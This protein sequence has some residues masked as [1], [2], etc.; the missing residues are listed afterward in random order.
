MKSK[1][2]QKESKIYITSMKDKR[3]M[4]GFKQKLTEWLWSQKDQEKHNNGPLQ[5]KEVLY[6]KYIFKPFVQVHYRCKQLVILLLKISPKII[7]LNA[8]DI[9]I[10]NLNRVEEETMKS[11][12]RKKNSLVTFLF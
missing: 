3:R 11:F 4:R 2:N 7:W 10:E 6:E 8:S 12:W 9:G 5:K 1:S